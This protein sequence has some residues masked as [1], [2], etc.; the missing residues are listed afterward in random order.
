MTRLEALRLLLNAEE[1]A[2]KF[3]IK[4]WAAIRLTNRAV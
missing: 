3:W 1:P 4:W 2:P